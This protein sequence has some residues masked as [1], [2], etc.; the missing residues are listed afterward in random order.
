[1]SERVFL[2]SWLRAVPCSGPQVAKNAVGDVAERLVA[3]V[4]GAQLWDGALP[5]FTVPDR[6]AVET[7]SSP[8]ALLPDAWW[9]P[10]S[11][12]IEVK[13]GIDRFYTTARQWR[14]YRW[15]R[16]TQRSG[17]PIDRP[18]VFY[19]FIRYD[20]PKRS[21]RYNNS[22][23]LVDDMLCGL[24]YIVV[25]DS[26]LVET[27]IGESGSDMVDHAGPLSPMLGAW[28]AHYNIRAH[29]LQAWADAPR[30][31]LDARGFI[32]WHVGSLRN[33]LRA[34]SAEL[35]ASGWAAIPDIPVVVLRPSRRS[36]PGPAVFPGA[37]KGLTCPACGSWGPP[38][39]CPKC[40]A[41]TAF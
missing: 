1:M 15:A 2:G 20:L 12:L 32:Y 11:A 30:E 27:F 5:A 40:G 10:Q 14:S 35:A 37:Q 6:V 17:L 36:R 4:L 16:D 31:Q 33:R 25:A 21:D 9:A 23:A 7:D 8:Y 41:F 19:A 22:H 26:K 34:A 3:R 38:G 24:R 18:R 13:A 28:H 39:D 29:R